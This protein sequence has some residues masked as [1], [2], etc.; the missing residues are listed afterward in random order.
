VGG[1]RLW[2][3]ISPN[4]TWAGLL[5]A[6]LAAGI[7]GATFAQ[8][9]TGAQLA[10]AVP[11]ALAL[12]LVSQ[13]GDLAE[14]A[15]KRGHGVKDASDLIP[16][17]GGFLDRMDGLVAVATAAGLMTLLLNANAPSHALLFGP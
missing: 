10:Y 5:S 9:V 4:K 14:S 8:T 7:V 12:G 2:P 3:S 16:G 11:I 17:H 1:V 15:L 13:M 6:I